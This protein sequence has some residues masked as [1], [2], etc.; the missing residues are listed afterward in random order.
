MPFS[1]IGRPASP[2]GE[3]GCSIVD[4]VPTFGD[5]N[6]GSHDAPVIQRALDRQVKPSSQP[7]IAVIGKNRKRRVGARHVHDLWSTS[8]SMCGEGLLLIRVPSEGASGIPAGTV[9][10]IR[11]VAHRK[12]AQR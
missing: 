9:S 8:A 1:C 2:V 6:D 12:G 5:Q 4:E 11:A 3:T 7:N 10:P